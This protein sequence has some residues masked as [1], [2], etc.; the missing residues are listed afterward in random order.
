MESQTSHWTKTELEIYILLLC[1]NADSVVT[2]EEIDAIKS[3]FE[4][5]KFENI[6]SEFSSDTEEEGL[7][8]IE[9]NICLHEY[10]YKELSEIK[11]EMKNIFL[12]DNK[13]NMMERN[14]ERI[15]NRILY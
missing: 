1:A 4:P 6:Y 5:E 3:K 12:S 11:S 7:R 13:F 8:K 15:L 14:L 2:K 9:G 10:S